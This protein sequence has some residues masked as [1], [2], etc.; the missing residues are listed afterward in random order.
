MNRRS[1]PSGRTLLSLAALAACSVTALP[2]HA[3]SNPYILRASQEFTYDSNLFRRETRVRRDLISSTTLGA[4]IDQQYGRQRYL[5]DASITGNIY[6]NNDQLNSAGYGLL[7]GM[8]WEAAQRLA[9]TIRLRSSRESARYEDFGTNV[10]TSNENL[11]RLNAID[12]TGRYGV[13][14]KLSL[15]G[16]GGY[17]D[18][19]YSNAAFDDREYHQGYLG[20]GLRY[21][22]SDFLSFGL[23]AR[24]TDGA[25]PNIPA[26]GGTV[27]D[28]FTR[29]DLE[30]STNWRPTGL[31]TID[32]RVSWTS[33]DHETVES[34]DFDG[35]TGSVRWLYRPTSKSRFSVGISRDTRSRS[36]AVSELATVNDDS[37][38]S[39]RY[40]GGFEWLATAKIT[41]NVD[42]SYSRDSYD[43]PVNIDG[44][45]QRQTG[46]GNT[47]AYSLG[48][49][50][51]VTRTV[52]VGC[53]V[54]R[55]SRSADVDAVQEYT[56]N[57]AQCSVS[58]EIQ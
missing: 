42:A 25:Y 38:L 56:A 4:A 44:L 29:D 24:R 57:L 21:R 10:D 9:G 50:Y 40:F 3:Q 33:E 48:V 39:T 49:K 32:A 43:Q 34:R 37:R 46:D 35:V 15:E 47:Q 11:R 14:G 55:L 7:L 13:A 18:V 12:L 17:R 51:A 52:G 26:V 5:A 58:L 31:S 36:G 28:D 16:E 1:L 27:K 20:A 41:V 22:P 2:V 23:T 8:D 45:V 6:K 19:S 54:S 53:S 30:F